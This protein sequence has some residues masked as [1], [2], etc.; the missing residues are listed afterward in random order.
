MQ[1]IG[2]PILKDNY[3]WLLVSESNCLIIDPGESAPVIH[4]LVSRKL[5]PAAIITTHHHWDHTDGIPDLLARYPKIPV[6]GSADEPISLMTNALCDKDSV[7]IPGFP[8]ITAHT[9]P[10][11]TKH[12][13]IVSIGDCLFTGDT[14]FS[15]GCGRSF[16]CEPEVLWNSLKKIL[17]MQINYKIYPGHEYTLE[18]L[19]FAHHVLPMDS[20]IKKAY[21]L[22]K[23]LRQNNIPSV[24]STL[25]R[26]RRIN[27]F[28]LSKNR[29]IWPK[30]KANQPINDAQ[31]CFKVLRNWKNDFFS[32][33]IAPSE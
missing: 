19:A 3:C 27:I 1:V 18:N 32:G 25:N 2:L 5:N 22:T 8:T 17:D 31:T 29:Q 33:N 12:H 6:I 13:C 23:I 30:I 20:T 28:L 24:P 9:T 14:L 16:E 11:H 26:E 21:D 7:D 15:G 4:A 10:G